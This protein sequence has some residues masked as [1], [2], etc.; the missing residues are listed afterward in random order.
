VLLESSGSDEVVVLPTAA[1]YEH[2]DRVAA[3]AA[4]WFESLG[5]RA[6]PVMAVDRRGAHDPEHVEAVR[7]ARF[8]YLSEGSPMHLRSVLLHSPLWDAI[9]AAWRDGAV[10]AGSAAGAMVL[11]DPM[12]DTRGGAFT[13]GLGLV[14]QMALITRVDTWTDDKLH[15]TLQLAPRGLPVVGVDQA[16]AL[17]CEDGAWRAEGVGDVTVWVDG[18]EAPLDAL[19][20]TA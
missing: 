15:R 9:V 18:H 7:K 6:R 8:L 4:R 16:T 3:V 1:A 19:P 2:P 14:R 12:V 17:L 11:C 20:A 13:V 10:L 5:A